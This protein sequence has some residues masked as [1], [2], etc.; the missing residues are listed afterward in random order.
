VERGLPK[1]AISQV[2]LKDFETWPN[3]VYFYTNCA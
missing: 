1:I 2:T 3:L